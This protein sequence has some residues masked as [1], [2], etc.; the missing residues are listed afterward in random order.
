M[1]AHES[2]RIVALGANINSAIKRGN[3]MWEDLDGIQI[4]LL[5]DVNA[6][7]LHR[8]QKGCDE[9]F[10]WNRNKKSAAGSAAARLSC[11]ESGSDDDE[12]S[13]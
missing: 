3:R 1:A 13:L 6:R 4:A 12:P 7:K 10:G 2:L 5:D 11:Y 9:A 8:L